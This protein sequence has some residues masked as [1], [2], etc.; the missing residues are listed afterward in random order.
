MDTTEK[1]DQI[2]RTRMEIM[3]EITQTLIYFEHLK[4]MVAVII[5]TSI[6]TQFA[7]NDSTIISILTF[8]DNV[9]TLCNKAVAIFGLTNRKDAKGIIILKTLTSKLRE[10]SST[11]NHLAHSKSIFKVVQDEL[12]DLIEDLDTIEIQKANLRND[13]YKNRRTKLSLVGIKNLNKNVYI[14]SR[15]FDSF[16][17]AILRPLEARN[18]MYDKELNLAYFKECI[19]TTV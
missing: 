16:S 19:F 2:H 9:N 1:K 7:M 3:T 17:F 11:R 12:I 8:N 18:E 4:Q 6:F 15:G 13:G 10:L 14:L 5:R